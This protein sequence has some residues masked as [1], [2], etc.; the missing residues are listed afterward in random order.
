MIKIKNK[1]FL[2]SIVLF[3]MIFGSLE[4]I[5]FLGLGLLKVY[6]GVSYSPIY[7][8][9]I[10]DNHKNNIENLINNKYQ[11]LKHSPILGWTIK[12]NGYFNNGFYEANSIGIRSKK[13][14]TIIPAKNKLRISCFG[15]SFTHC[16]QVSNNETWQAQ[17]ERSNKKFEVMNFGVGGYGTDQAFLRYKIEGVKYKPDFVLIGLQ[18]EN[19]KRILNVYR[20]FYD[21][22]TNLTLSKPR[23]KINDGELKIISNPLSKIDDYKRLIKNPEVLLPMLG[24]NDFFYNS[25]YGVGSFDFISFIKL[26]KILS[27]AI[28]SNGPTNSID[29]RYK[30]NSEYFNLLTMIIDAFYKE[31]IKN[32]S[33]PIV[34]VFPNQ[35]DI[36][37]KRNGSDHTYKPLLDFLE[38][39][40]MSY[41]DTFPII[42]QSNPSL[43]LNKLFFGHYTAYTN[44]VIADGIIKYF[45]TYTTK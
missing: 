33:I 41:I 36:S 23:F 10:S 38:Q 37:L 12:P 18:P 7:K 28:S 16:D 5:S 13:E 30:K 27:S 8:T 3:M 2:F 21:E 4:I 43:D 31:V 22:K 44:S 11:Y 24:K 34:V 25:K 42:K 1:S 6:R 39:K 45:E 17:I 26:F 9:E 15:D 35:Y 29:G 32:G 19:I 40:K 14:Y 20:P